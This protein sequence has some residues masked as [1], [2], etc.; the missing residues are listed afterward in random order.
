MSGGC[1]VVPKFNIQLEGG[2]LI[3][4]ATIKVKHYIQ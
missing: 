4:F 1:A 2:E 3:Y